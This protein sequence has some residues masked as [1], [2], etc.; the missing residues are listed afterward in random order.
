MALIGETLD[1]VREVMVFGDSG[2]IA[3]SPPGRRPEWHAGRRALIWPNGAEAWA[4]SASSPEN[5]RGPQFDCIW[6]DELGKWKRARETWDMLQ[7]A[8]R[9][10]DN[11][12]AMVTTTPRNIG[13]LKEILSAAD[14][15]VS[16]APTDANRANLAPGFFEES[17][18]GLWWFAFGT[19]GTCR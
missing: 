10:G 15:V 18:Y 2:I 5:L 3:S 14:T 7:F 12:Q 19:T 11:P 6:A 9:L 1:Q 4:M 17:V 16:R 8:L 13:V